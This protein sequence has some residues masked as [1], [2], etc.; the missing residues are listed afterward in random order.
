MLAICWTKAFDDETST[1]TCRTA[2]SQLDA[3]IPNK[4]GY[5]ITLCP[6]EPDFEEMNGGTDQAISGRFFFLFSRS[7]SH[8]K[9][10]LRCPGGHGLPTATQVC[11]GQAS[12]DNNNKY[13]TH[14][15]DQTLRRYA[16]CF[17]SNNHSV[18]LDF[19]SKNI[20]G[21]RARAKVF[22]HS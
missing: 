2:E 7:Q 19:Q 3:N 17:R 4:A 18:D 15:P 13:F 1:F 21:S 9:S 8:S 11:R 16:A 6:S 14:Y 10:V 22:K 20:Y 12:W 5:N